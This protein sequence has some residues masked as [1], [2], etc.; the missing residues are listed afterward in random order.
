MRQFLNQWLLKTFSQRLQT[1]LLAGL[2]VLGCA[3][4]GLV[5]AQPAGPSFQAVIDAGSSGTRLYLY[6]ARQGSEGPTVSLLFEEDP[7]ALRGLSSY[8]DKPDQAG[9]GEIA[10]LLV[11]LEGFLT[12]KAIDPK[13]VSVSVLATAGMRLVDSSAANRIY[14][15]V[16]QEVT[17]RGFSLRQA[18]TITGQ[19]EGVYGWVD[20]NYLKGNL[21][22]G[23]TTEGI[24]EVGGASAQVALAVK[25]T[26]GLGN[27][28]K[29]VNI[30]A[31]QYDV[32][33]VSFLGLG[34]NEARRSM[35]QAVSDEGLTQNPCY[36]NSASPDVS[37]EAVR[38]SAGRAST[39]VP[40]DKAS[41]SPACFDLYLGVVQRTSA[42]PVNQFPV[43]RFHTVPGF[44]Q[45]R[46]VLIS[47]I[48]HKMREW[49]LLEAK[50]PDRGLLSEVFRRCAGADAWQV[51]ASLEGTGP[52]AQNSCANATYLYTLMFSSRGLALPSSNVQVLG[53]ING[54]SLTWTRGYALLAAG[55]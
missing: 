14:E 35:V 15:S 30:G 43:A 18:K 31:Q 6:E 20:V 28:V 34:Q 49:D 10:P 21:G 22:Q 3:G 27:A 2:M 9:T 52:F 47:S 50:R 25:S 44:D 24:V 5:S 42:N 40:G 29:R 54:Q 11:A 39:K 45:T 8:V 33:S 23:R 51:L 26:A 4:V 55:S 53:E 32:L 41:Y 16:R 48:Y 17:S 1:F 12:S 19:E 37:F 13:A 7:D 46:F 38:A 36:A